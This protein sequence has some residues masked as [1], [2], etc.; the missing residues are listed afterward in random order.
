MYRD[1]GIYRDIG[2]RVVRDRIGG[3]NVMRHPGLSLSGQNFVLLHLGGISVSQIGSSRCDGRCS[4]R[5]NR[6]HG[7]A[8]GACQPGTGPVSEED[9]RKSR[10]NHFHRSFIHRHHLCR[11]A[12]ANEKRQMANSVSPGAE[13]LTRRRA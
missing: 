2:V 3:I 11:V 12:P 6:A 10:P 7:K 5:G 9:T 1:I 4:V 8:A 13:F